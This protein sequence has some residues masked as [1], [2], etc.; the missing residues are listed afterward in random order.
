MTFTGVLTSQF[1]IQA[2]EL[3]FRAVNTNIIKNSNYSGSLNEATHFSSFRG[4]IGYK[5]IPF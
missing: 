1:L 4:K 5:M 3:F 2:S